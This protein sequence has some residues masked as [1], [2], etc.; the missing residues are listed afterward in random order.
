MNFW[1]AQKSLTDIKLAGNSDSGHP[2]IDTEMGDFVVP[3]LFIQESSGQS[4][5]KTE[6]SANRL[7]HAQTKQGS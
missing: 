1:R 5:G 3:Q 6:I 7:T 4:A 2:D